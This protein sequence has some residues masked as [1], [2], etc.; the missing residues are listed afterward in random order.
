MIQSSKMQGEI[1][2]FIHTAVAAAKAPLERELF[3][4]HV[5]GMHKLREFAPT[6]NFCW[7]AKSDNLEVD[8]KISDFNSLKLSMLTSWIQISSSTTVSNEPLQ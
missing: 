1:F 3:P 8:K 7:H 6:W 2:L 5:T 4:I